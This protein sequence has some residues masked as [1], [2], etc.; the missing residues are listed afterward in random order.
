MPHRRLY[1]KIAV[2]TGGSRGIGAAICKKLSREGATVILTYGHEA[3]PAERVCDELVLS[4]GKA[5]AIRCD[6]EI[7]DQIDSLF[8]TIK[9]SYQNIDVLVNNAAVAE[10]IPFE[11][12]DIAQ[13]AR[14]FNIN[15][16]GPMLAIQKAMSLWAG[17]GSVINISSAIVRECPPHSL[18]YTSTKAA[19]DAMTQVLAQE[20]GPK[21]VRVNSVSPGL[22]DTKLARDAMPE[23]MFAKIAKHTPLQRLGT[24]DDIANVVAFLASEESYWITGEI[25]GAT[26][27]M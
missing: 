24:P 26:G 3:E 27:G 17:S 6:M 16:R 8:Q 4:G 10:M 15:V 13:F 25:I 18:L 1:N 22:V 9:K 2:V 12:N 7:P 5:Q 14:F 11:E 21:R 23:P 20:L 19:L